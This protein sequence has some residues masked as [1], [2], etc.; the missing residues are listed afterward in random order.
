[1]C[2]AGPHSPLPSVRAETSTTTMASGMDV[3]GGVPAA[4]PAA[5]TRLIIERIEM[6]NFK[7]YFGEQVIGPFHKVGRPHCVSPSTH[8]N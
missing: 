7:S 4:E 6:V 5:G 1:M 2:T 8:Q 3:D